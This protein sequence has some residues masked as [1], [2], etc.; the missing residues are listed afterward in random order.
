MHYYLG[1]AS[2][3]SPG[4]LR[5]IK[6]GNEQDDSRIY[7]V[8][9]ENIPCLEVQVPICSW[10][11]F[12][13]ACIFLEYLCIGYGDLAYF[14]HIET[15]VI[16]ELETDLYFG[17]FYVDD[18][19]LFL[20]SASHVYCLNANCNLIWKSPHLAIDGVV[21]DAVED[22]CIRV[23]CEMDPPGGWVERCLALDTG[24]E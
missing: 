1:T 3:Q 11:P 8:C 2:A 22:D 20:T 12:D 5:Q 10:N 9:Q 23:S 16:K 24:M 15:G 4:K 7:T 18:K 14:L 13:T 6:I 19:R 17:Y 21:I